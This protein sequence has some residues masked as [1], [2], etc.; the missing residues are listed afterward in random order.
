[1]SWTDT[2][3][4]TMITRYTHFDYTHCKYTHSIYT[5]QMHTIHALYAHYMHIIY[6]Y[7]YTLTSAGIHSQV[8]APTAIAAAA[9]AGRMGAEG[10]VVEPQGPDYLA[11][12]GI[13]G[14]H[15]LLRGAHDGIQADDV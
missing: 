5:H 7:I 9:A 8:H 3:H 12:V 13:A 4:A 15:L 6:T 1:M 10:C 2:T 11:E 14:L